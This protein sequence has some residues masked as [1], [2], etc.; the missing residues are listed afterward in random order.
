MVLPE[1]PAELQIVAAS[2][3]AF[4]TVLVSIRM[5]VM[6]VNKRKAAVAVQVV[7]AEMRLIAL[8]VQVALVFRGSM[9]CFMAAAEEAPPR[10]TKV[11]LTGRAVVAVV[12]V[13]E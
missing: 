10:G 5:E 13:E 11:A 12:W 6:A 9:A 4:H 8:E 7:E 2:F 3:P 1:T